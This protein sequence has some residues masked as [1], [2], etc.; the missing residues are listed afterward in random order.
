MLI[1]LQG[2]L[3]QGTLLQGILL[4]GTGP[5]LVVEYR[6]SQIVN[7]RMDQNLYVLGRGHHKVCAS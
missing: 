1:L 5:R 6:T 7:K 3:L 4:S 2:T